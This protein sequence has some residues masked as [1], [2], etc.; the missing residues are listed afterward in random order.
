LVSGGAVYL[1]E[2]NV[3]GTGLIKGPGGST[4]IGLLSGTGGS[5]KFYN[6]ATIAGTTTA[7]STT[8]G[9][10]TVA[11]GVGI[12]GDVYANKFVGDG[13][14]LTNLAG[15]TTKTTGTWSVSTGS[16]TYSI[17]VPINAAYQIWVR[18]N[19]PNGIITY[20]ATVHV[21]NTNVPV[22][23]SQRAWNYTGGGSPILFT[24]IPNQIVGT[25]GTIS[26]AVVATTTANRF[27]FG[28]N[29]TSG[30]TQTVYWGYVTL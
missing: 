30:S 11:G 7:T 12:G 1:G 17:T 3:N 25:E 2:L 15:V 5:V 26:T 8:T 20:Q 13:S 23:G 6:T 24:S 27:D 4:H 21:S 14:S 19:I 9:A 16:G 28:I 18:C 10:L 29:N 22:L